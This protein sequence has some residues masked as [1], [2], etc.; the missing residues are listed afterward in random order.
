MQQV[1]FPAL[2]SKCKRGSMIKVEDFQITI[3]NEPDA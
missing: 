3:R 2:C 1:T